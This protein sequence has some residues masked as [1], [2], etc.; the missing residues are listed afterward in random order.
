MKAAILALLASGAAVGCTGTAR[1]L[2]AYRTDTEKMLA[3]R[4]AQLTTCYDEALAR[5]AKLGGTVTVRFVVSSKT[6]T[7]T[8]ATIV[9]DKSTASVL[10]N[11][12]V[13]RAVE[14]LKLAPADRND[15]HATFVYEFKPPTPAV[16]LTLPRA[17]G[18]A[19]PASG[20]G[21]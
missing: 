16:S 21:V 14:G 1:G 19:T 13:L 10:L 4:D 5:D 20:S 12:C 8:D 18:A 15:G 2:E 3:T 11:N 7:V 6:G 17:D 9:A